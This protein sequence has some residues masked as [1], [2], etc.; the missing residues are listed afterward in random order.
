M[1]RRIE[2]NRLM[3]MIRLGLM[4]LVVLILLIFKYEQSSFSLKESIYFCC[5]LFPV[6]LGTSY[7][8][9]YRL[10]PKYLLTGK[11]KT[12]SL[13][14]VY[15]LIVSVYLETWIV[16]FSLVLLA[17]YQFSS[18]SPEV[19]DVTH[20]ALLLYAIVFIHGFSVLFKHFINQK[21]AKEALQQQ[22]LKNEAKSIVVVSDRKQARLEEDQILFIES[23]SD[24]VRIHLISR[25]V[26]SKATISSLE[27]ELS[28]DFVRIHRSYLVNKKHVDSFTKEKLKIAGHEL[29]I[30]RKYKES[31]F[32]VL[33]R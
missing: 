19:S 2:K 4:W 12:F 7:Y 25:V 17:D 3:K 13:Y 6:I 30:T 28:N 26:V 15:L 8:F 23:L 5:M 29:N 9:N 10:V 33:E 31:A 16:I 18:L 24:Y 32:S 14:A 27:S 20:M 21:S 11:Y 22:Q 1:I